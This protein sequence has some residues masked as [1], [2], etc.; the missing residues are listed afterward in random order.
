VLDGE[1]RFTGDD[2]G[3][4]S[5]AGVDCDVEPELC[6]ALPLEPTRF[7]LAL[8]GENRSPGKGTP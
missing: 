8:P 1:P 2:V 7:S 3:L 5:L 6:L 4:Y